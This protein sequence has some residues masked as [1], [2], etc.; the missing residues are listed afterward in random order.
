MNSR[1]ALW[2]RELAK[3]EVIE[4][5]VQLY[6]GNEYAFALGFDG[7]GAMPQI[8]L[9][10]DRGRLVPAALGRT[11]GALVLRAVSRRAGVYHLRV[12]AGPEQVVLALTYVYR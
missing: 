10:D 2:S 1:R 12:A 6:S 3:G 7:A 8:S 5:P 9:R 11:P 4:V